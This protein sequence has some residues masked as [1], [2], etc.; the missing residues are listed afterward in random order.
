MQALKTITKTTT[1]TVESVHADT[2]YAVIQN[3]YKNLQVI[4]AD[5]T[6]AS[7]FINSA[8]IYAQLITLYAS[9]ADTTEYVA[10]DK[11]MQCFTNNITYTDESSLFTNVVADTA[12]Q[13]VNLLDYT[14]LSA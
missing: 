11:V 10:L 3:A 7:Y 1:K 5:C 4:E 13:N 14:Y 9:F 8:N 12:M 6:G 2:V